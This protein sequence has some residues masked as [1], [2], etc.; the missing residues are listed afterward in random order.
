MQ[1]L[2]SEVNLVSFREEQA[3]ARA[4]G[5][6]LGIGFGFE[7]APEGCS[8]PNSDMLQGWDGVTVRIDP[9][10]RVTVLTGVTSPGSGNETGIA[11]IVADTLGVT[12][13]SINVVQ[14]DTDKCPYGLGNFSSRSTMIGG[15]AAMLAAQDIREKLVKV[16]ARL[17]Q[18]DPAEL[19]LDDDKVYVRSSPDRH[20]PIRQVARAIYSG[21]FSP[22]MEGIEPGLDV[23]RYFR[24]GNVYHHPEQQGRFNP[25]P[26]WPFMAS[27]AVV[28]VD[29]DS[30]F[31]KVLRY[32]A[33]HDCGKVI[34]PMLVDAQTHGAIAQGLGGTLYEELI[35]D[36]SGQLL[37]TTLM[38]YTLPTAVEMPPK[39]VLGHQ[40]T[41]T[42]ATPLGTKGAG[43]TGIASTMSAVTS[44]VED[45]LDIPGLALM[46]LPLK[47]QRVWRAIR[48]VERHE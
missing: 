25:Y 17:M 19:E 31:V 35:Y 12:L 13:E 3:A 15:S 42:F 4:Q 22:H 16:A 24:I 21:A 27:A 8:M 30:G 36:E 44:A 48:E 33:V 41:P 43:E 32:F 26:T 11:Q 39:L 46:H 14:G 9:R 37:T 1:K 2:L 47:P 29:R 5:R 10:G 18:A 40:E 45:A 20:M 28:E 6:M 38:D 23:T 34:N 7:L